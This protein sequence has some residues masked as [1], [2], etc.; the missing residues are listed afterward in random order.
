MCLS[1]TLAL[2]KPNSGKLKQLIA[3]KMSIFSVGFN[4]RFAPL[5]LKMKQLIGNANM[6][7]NIIATMNAG[8]IP[9]E[10]WLHDMEVGGEE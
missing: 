7:I 1:K 5:A 8:F 10:V 9:S 2:T 3:N 4:R 6:P